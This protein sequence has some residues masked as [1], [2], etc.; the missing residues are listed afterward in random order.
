MNYAITASKTQEQLHRFLGMFSPHFSIPELRFL[1]QMLYG[2]QAARDV[3][4]SCIGR[5]LDEP[6]SMKKL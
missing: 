6:I 5:A 1:G 2:I 4:L 3:K